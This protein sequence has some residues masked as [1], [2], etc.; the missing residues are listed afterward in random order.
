MGKKKQINMGITL[1]IIIIFVSTNSISFINST[2]MEIKIKELNQS[3]TTRIS[4]VIPSS[5]DWRNVNGVD[6]TTPIKNQA[7]SPTCEA[8][9][10]CAALETIVQYK[11][12]YPFGCDLSEAHLFFYAGGSIQLGGVYLS[13][14]ADYL[15]QHGVPDEGCFPDPHRPYD[16]PFESLPGWEN[17]TV[18]I[19]SWGWVEK[20]DTAIK[21]ALITYGPLVICIYNRENLLFYRQGIYMPKGRINGGH[22]VAIVGYN[23]SQRCWIIRNSAGEQWGEKGYVRVSY[24]ADTSDHPFI[25]DFYGGTGIL[26]VDGVY[27]NFMP[28]A[29]HIQI[30]KPTF[31]H[32]YI[33]GFDLPTIFRKGMFMQK[34]AP[35]LIGKNTVDVTATNTDRVEFYFDGNLTYT[36]EEAPYTWDL[37]ASRGLHTLETYAY[38]NGTISKD[39]VDIYVII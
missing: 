24:D 14:A 11:V 37:K 18:K 29:P 26:Y 8:Y 22:V 32:T 23:D 2:A 3:S 30:D 9:G 31:F 19:T 36:D 35:R 1:G 6:F 38:H 27:G 20:N 39:L 34:G 5:F 15:I 16:S 28:D 13:D 12:G 4:T 25:A 33:T 21:K 10:L 17:R 7:P